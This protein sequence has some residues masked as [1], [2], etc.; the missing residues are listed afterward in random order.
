[1]ED[2]EKTITISMEEYKELLIIKGRYEELKERYINTQP[3]IMREPIK[4]GDWHP[5]LTKSPTVTFNKEVH[6]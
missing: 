2:R 6:V 3:I 5:D 1:M 4:S